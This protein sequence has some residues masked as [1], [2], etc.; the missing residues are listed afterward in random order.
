MDLLNTVKNILR[1][2]IAVSVAATSCLL[3][4]GCS[5]QE[6]N[7]DITGMYQLRIPDSLQN[8]YVAPAN[9]QIMIQEDNRIVY[10]T[11]L[12]NKPYL[13]IKGT[14]DVLAEN[15]IVVQWE[16]GKLPDTILIQQ[17]GDQ[18]SIMIGS[19]S[20]LKN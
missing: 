5:Q 7:P 1:L 9:G 11:T 13:D 16:S 17:S 19:T 12:N 10:Q 8:A 14:Y 6:N 3:L 15:K 4:I 18:K 20:Y 2:F